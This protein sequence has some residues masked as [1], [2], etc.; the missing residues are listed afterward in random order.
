MQLPDGPCHLVLQRGVMIRAP[1]LLLLQAQQQQQRIL[2]SNQKI[3][4]MAG[5]TLLLAL[6]Y[7]S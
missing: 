4:S 2:C 7:L 1:P 6:R 5:I 3:L